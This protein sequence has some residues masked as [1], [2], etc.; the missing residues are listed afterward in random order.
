MS[1]SVNSGSCNL[2][3]DSNVFPTKNE[4]VQSIVDFI[5]NHPEDFEG[6]DCHI[7]YLLEY[8]EDDLYAEIEKY[9][10]MTDGDENVFTSYNSE[11]NNS[12]FLVHEYI[13]EHLSNFMKEEF[14]PVNWVCDDSKA[15]VSSGQNYLVRGGDYKV[16]DE[17]VNTVVPPGCA[18]LILT[19]REIQ[20]I[21]YILEQAQHDYTEDGDDK[22]EYESILAKTVAL[23]VTD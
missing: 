15:G 3:I 5:G 14:V 9:I 16:L 13:I 10:E 20:Q 18:A 12:D 17:M 11:E 21:L 22:D 19:S 23:K 7:S 6:P 1:Y 4:L 8:E 2:T